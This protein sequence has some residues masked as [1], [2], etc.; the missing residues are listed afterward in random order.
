MLFSETGQ[1]SIG[2]SEVEA[3]SIAPISSLTLAAHPATGAPGLLALAG[4]EGEGAWEGMSV[5]S[6]SASGRRESGAAKLGQ[7]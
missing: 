2:P 5:I 4:S 7:E 6:V 3:Q 1:R